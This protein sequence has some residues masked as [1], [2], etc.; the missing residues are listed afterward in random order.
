MTRAL[1]ALLLAGFAVN[2]VAADE[3]QQHLRRMPQEESDAEFAAKQARV[4]AKFANIRRRAVEEKKACTADL[5]NQTWI[6]K[7]AVKEL[8][9]FRLDYFKDKPVFRFPFVVLK[10]QLGGCHQNILLLGENHDMDAETGRDAR[11][12][13]RDFPLRGYEEAPLEDLSKLKNAAVFKRIM[14]EKKGIRSNPASTAQK[15]GLA[16]NHVGILKLDNTT[17]LRP[18][19]SA[20]SMDPKV[21]TEFLTNLTSGILPLEV[22]DACSKDPA[23]ALNAEKTKDVLTDTHKFLN[24]FGKFV[25]QPGFPRLSVRLEVGTLDTYDIDCSNLDQECDRY[26]GIERNK[27]MVRNIVRAFEN[28]SCGVPMV[29]LMGEAHLAGMSKRLEAEGFKIHGP[30]AVPAS[31]IDPE[32]LLLKPK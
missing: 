12:I 25:G 30:N 23:A 21:W 26:V 32:A 27:R 28:V 13:Y 1:L 15:E 11:E 5:E 3:E 14:S 4:R 16:I 31:N 24:V 6:P 18:R 29:A 2:V 17:V 7:R 19:E 10:R 9:V 22:S 8:C 20:Q